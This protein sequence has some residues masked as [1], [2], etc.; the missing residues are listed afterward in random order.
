VLVSVYVNRI[1]TESAGH[2]VVATGVEFSH[3]GATYVAIA[4]KEVILSAGYVSIT[5]ES[6]LVDYWSPL[7]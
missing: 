7:L 3:E 6:V 4:N 1:I 5:M 2:E